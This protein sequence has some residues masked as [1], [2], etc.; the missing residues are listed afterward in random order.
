[1]MKDSDK[2]NARDDSASDI[3]KY[4]PSAADL[5]KKPIGLRK[6]IKVVPEENTNE[7]KYQSGKKLKHQSA[8]TSDIESGKFSAEK[9]FTR[10]PWKRQSNVWTKSTEEH[11]FGP[12]P[13]TPK[14]LK[15]QGFKKKSSCEQKYIYH[16]ILQQK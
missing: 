8:G 11:T 10:L 13:K 1:M 6:K 15:Q 2:K 12:P 7:S 14:K 3:V 5:A 9:T 16:K 4:I